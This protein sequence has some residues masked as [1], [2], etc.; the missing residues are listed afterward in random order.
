M[1]V[2]HLTIREHRHSRRFVYEDGDEALAR[3]AAAIAAGLDAKLD[4]VLRS[5]MKPK[6]RAP[7][8]GR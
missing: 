5:P 1:K 7:V 4:E 8:P 3:L 6:E 2:Y